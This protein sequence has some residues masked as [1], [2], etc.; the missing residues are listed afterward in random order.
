MRAVSDLAALRQVIERIRG[1]GAPPNEEATKLQMVLPI[2]SALG[3]HATDPSRLVP[4]YAVGA[5]KS[6]RAD[7]ALLAPGGQRPVALLEVK[8]AGVQLEEHVEQTLRYAFYEGV[9]LCALTT[10]LVW[11]LYL[12]L[13]KGPPEERRFAEL[14]VT[15]DS[16]DQLLADFETY[17]EYTALV[18]HK[19]ERHAKEIIEARRDSERLN[20]EIPQVWRSMLNDPPQALIELIEARVFSS[21]RLRPSSDQIGEFLAGT[22]GSVKAD[23][24][25]A[26]QPASRK[27][28][29]PKQL[30]IEK[31]AGKAK[32]SKPDGFQ[33]WGRKYPAKKWTEVWYGVAEALYDRHPD[34][35]GDAVG[36]PGGKLSY[37]EV[38]RG[39]L[40]APAHSLRGSQYW[41]GGHGS[42]KHLQSRCVNLLALFGY[43]SADI[44]FIYA[45]R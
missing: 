40:S 15:T 6:G 9:D 21:I 42:A 4:E 33:L 5:K 2:L 43:S 19:A 35:F 27:P 3:W 14:N 24:A 30:D 31:P 8:A 7:I 20:K 13:Q 18:E 22:T 32:S 11:W 23:R 1:L 36:R 29:A 38:D 10:G 17:L 16:L 41:V 28:P 12:P 25:S 44:E 39:R 37:V 34:R 26:P 45:S